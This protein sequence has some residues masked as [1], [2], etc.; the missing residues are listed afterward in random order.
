M[1]ILLFF[2]SQG[3]TGLPLVG[4][5][6]VWAFL[7]GLVFSG[8]VTADKQD[9]WQAARAS[10]LK[11]PPPLLVC[12]LLPPLSIKWREKLHGAY[13]AP[14]LLESRGSGKIPFLAATAAFSSASVC[15]GSRYSPAGARLRPGL[16][17]AERGAPPPLG[18]QL[19]AG[20]RGRAVWGAGP[21]PA[22]SQPG[23]RARL[24]APSP[25]RC[26]RSRLGRGGHFPAAVG[27]AGRRR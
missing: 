8:E 6:S 11:N 1:N 18:P 14:G 23:R 27:S 3:F 20:S 26:P 13:D 4:N 25:R 21:L 12:Q 7:A 2:L 17:P 22:P 10:R 15:E 16:R 9:G 5:F 19:P 24:P